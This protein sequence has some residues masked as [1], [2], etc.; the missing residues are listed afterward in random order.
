MDNRPC[1]EKVLDGKKSL[2]KPW[3][4]WTNCREV[5]YCVYEAKKKPQQLTMF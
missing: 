1:E 4:L 2:C 3:G 5:G